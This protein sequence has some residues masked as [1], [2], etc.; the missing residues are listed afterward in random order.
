MLSHLPL[1]VEGLQRPV[2][3]ACRERRFAPRIGDNF[4]DNRLGGESQEADASI[5]YRFWGAAEKT[6]RAV[7]NLTLSN[8][9]DRSN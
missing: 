2:G 4:G 5:A 8:V 1:A 6:Q 9:A 7:T 3:G